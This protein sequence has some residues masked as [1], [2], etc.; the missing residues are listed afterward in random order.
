MNKGFVFILS[1]Y[2]VIIN[3]GF[4]TIYLRSNAS[5]KVVFFL[6][7]KQ[8]STGAFCIAKYAPIVLQADECPIV[9]SANS[10]HFTK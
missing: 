10:L 9:R 2:V 7:K 3:G 6:Q 4:A 1:F 5:Q 8:K